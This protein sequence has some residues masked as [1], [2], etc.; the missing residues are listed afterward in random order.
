M[1]PDTDEAYMR[2]FLCYCAGI[3]AAAT[4]IAAVCLLATLA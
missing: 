1:N 2:A 3:M 4:L